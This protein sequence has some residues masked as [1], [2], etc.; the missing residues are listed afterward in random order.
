MKHVLVP[1]LGLFLSLNILAQNP[2][3]PLPGY[4]VTVD[5]DTIKGNLVVMKKNG[6]FRTSFQMRFEDES[7]RT[8][9]PKKTKYVKAGEMEFDAF[10]IPGNTE[11][12]YGFFYRKASGKVTMYE[13]QYEIYAMNQTRWIS[14]FYIKDDKGELLALTKMNYKKKLGEVLSAQ[15]A[16]VQKLEGTKLEEAYKVVEEYNETTK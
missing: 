2:G 8:F 15:P 12:D 11:G 14:E 9:A 16:L 1:V 5:G 7:T 4:A 6:N 10:A 13:Y 3:D